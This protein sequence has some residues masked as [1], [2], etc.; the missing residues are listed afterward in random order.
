MIMK[1]GLPVWVTPANGGY[2]KTEHEMRCLELEQYRLRTPRGTREFQ[3]PLYEFT[4]M[5]NGT[6]AE[7]HK[8]DWK[9]ERKHGFFW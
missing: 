5:E 1:K 8:D 4:S 2:M 6:I 7:I 9:K 3:R